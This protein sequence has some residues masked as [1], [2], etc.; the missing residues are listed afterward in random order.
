VRVRRLAAG[1]LLGLACLVG[2]GSVGARAQQQTPAPAPGVE[3]VAALRD[4]LDAL[5]AADVPRTDPRLDRVRA[6]L[7]LAESLAG[8]S[9]ALAPIEADL[10]RDP[11]GVD[12]ARARLQALIAAVQLPPGSVA[13]DPHASRTTLD[14]VYR[15]G[16]LA[17]LGRR[18]SSDDLV[19]RVGRGLL[20]ALRWLAS[21]L[22]GSLG[23]VPTLILAGL[24]L[25]AIVGFVLLR[26]QRAGMPSVRRIPAEPPARGVD[27]DQEWRLATEAAARGDHREAVRHAFRSALLAI[28]VRGRLTVDAAWTTSELLARARGDADL[29]AALAPAADSFDRAWYSGRPVSERDWELARD[30][31]QAVRRLAGRRGVAV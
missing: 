29:V 19:S 25:A 16:Q 5:P 30:R 4:A 2:A 22:V 6:P 23:L 11:A 28:A 7:R 9:T 15:E 1:V 14:D 8:D 18:G 17:G 27:P 10:D 21:H 12:D 20:D 3:F 24:V 31:C 13:E 26:L